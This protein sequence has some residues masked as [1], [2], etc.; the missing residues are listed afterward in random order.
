MEAGYHALINTNNQQENIENIHL[1]DQVKRKIINDTAADSNLKDSGSNGKI[2]NLHSKQILNEVKSNEQSF[3]DNL[4]CIYNSNCS[5]NTSIKKT[6]VRQ[7]ITTP[8]KILDAPEFRDD[9]C[10]LNFFVKNQ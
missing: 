1:Y 4:K 10:K 7:V 3:A 6:H 8:E 2:L 9:F 5:M